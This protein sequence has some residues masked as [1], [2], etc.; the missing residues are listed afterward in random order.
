MRLYSY[1]SGSGGESLPM[2][3]ISFSVTGGTDGLDKH[4][5]IQLS[6][7]SGSA[8]DV[9]PVEQLSLN[10]G[11]TNLASDGIRRGDIDA[12]SVNFFDSAS[13][14]SDY[15]LLSTEGG[16]GGKITL[17]HTSSGGSSDQVP[18]ES[19]SF[20]LNPLG[21]LVTIRP[22]GTIDGEADALAFRYDA[23]SRQVTGIFTD[24]DD[25]LRLCNIGPDGV[26]V[27]DGPIE[28][29]CGNA[30]ISMKDNMLGQTY[31]EVLPLGTMSIL[32]SCVLATDPGHSVVIGDDAAVEKLTVIGNICAT[33]T[34]GLCSDRRYKS[35]VE[36]IQ[37]AGELLQRLRGVRFDWNTKAYVE[38]Q[39]SSEPQIGLIAQE[40][41]E[42][43]PCVVS[44]GS[45]GYY[46]VDYARI[47]PI[48][49][50]AAKVQDKT[51]GDLK[52]QL[53]DLSA[54]VEMLEKLVV[55]MSS[56]PSSEDQ[57]KIAAK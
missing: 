51:I 8:G 56:A 13:S 48:L 9:R 35:N 50:E 19:I 54:R 6:G 21:P 55:R 20:S 10:F 25:P 32:G 52:S 24:V 39:F 30:G 5:G 11:A 16:T 33:G 44:R 7:T 12:G 42:V 57:K 40:V 49:I 46:S 15:I 37:G 47:V 3:E 4:P 41:Q 22:P 31:F 38:K 43:L 17:G 28:V 18:T 45:D 34:I 23:P 26:A 14:G 53:V 36:T 27:N 1:Q 29:K 2:E